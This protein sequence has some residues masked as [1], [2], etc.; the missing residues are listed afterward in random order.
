MLRS[1]KLRTHVCWILLLGGA[2]AFGC[3]GSEKQTGEPSDGGATNGDSGVGGGATTGGSGGAALGGGP[4]AGGAAGSGGTLV[5]DAAGPGITCGEATCVEGS[6]MCC[7]GESDP[8]CDD[9]QCANAIARLEC[10]DSTDCPGERCCY[11]NISAMNWIVTRCGASCDSSEIIQ[12]CTEAGDCDNGDSCHVF[13]C[14][15]LDTRNVVI[16]LCTPTA[17]WNCE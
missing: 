12:V 16:G 4:S 6:Q 17:P 3:G 5:L 2:A 14:G 15:G 10:D 9:Y 11:T 7:V 1:A 13:V 8:W